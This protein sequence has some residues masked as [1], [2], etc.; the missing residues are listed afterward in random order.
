VSS[1]K[2]RGLRYGW[3]VNK[4]GKHVR[5]VVELVDVMMMMITLQQQ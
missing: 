1:Y 2:G 4:D 3:F 5:L